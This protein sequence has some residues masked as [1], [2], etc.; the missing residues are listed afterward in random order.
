MYFLFH[1]LTDTAL[2]QLTGSGVSCLERSLVIAF[3]LCSDPVDLPFGLK[4]QGSV[5][6]QNFTGL[7]R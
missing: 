2:R 3:S 7:K 4:C 6:G 1:L 5:F